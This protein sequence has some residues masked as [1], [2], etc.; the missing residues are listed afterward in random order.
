LGKEKS[1]NN[2]KLK[3]KLG[4]KKAQVTKPFLNPL[5]SIAFSG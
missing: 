3:V 2:I 1:P 5:R 4:M